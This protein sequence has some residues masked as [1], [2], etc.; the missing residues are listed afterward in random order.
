MYAAEE[1]LSLLL[2]TDFDPT[3]CRLVDSFHSFLKT[4]PVNTLGTFSRVIPAENSSASDWM[5]LSLLLVGAEKN[6]TLKNDLVEDV[7][8]DSLD[9]C[10][11]T[12]P[13]FLWL[14]ASYGFRFYGLRRA[15]KS[16]F[17]T[18]V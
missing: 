4:R 6:D 5:S 12:A 10:C 9:Q 3:I 8:G 16:R 18:L 2:A 13:Q 14:M 17:T 7:K 1:S 11:G 15:S